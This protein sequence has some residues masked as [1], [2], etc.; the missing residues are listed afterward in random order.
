MGTGSTDVTDI[1]TNPHGQVVVSVI[2]VCLNCVDTLPATVDSLHKQTWPWREWVVMD[3]ASKDGTQNVVMNSAERPACF[4][5]QPDKGIYDAMNKALALATGDVVYFLNADDALYDEN[6]LADVAREFGADPE[7]DFL[8]G[9]IVIRKPHTRTHKRYGYINRWTL[10][11]EDLCHQAVFVRRSLFDKVGKFDLQWR[12]SADYD[13]FLRVYAAGRKVKYID[14]RVAYFAAGGFH[15]TNAKALAD[16]RQALR[17]RYVSPLKLTVGSFLSR[18]AHK[19][20]KL[21]HG[22]YKIGESLES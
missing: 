18:A 16:E 11:Y 21:L 1:A 15:A 14:R 6:V 8:F 9:S 17:L 19:V 10:P 2:T 20:S 12:T 7:L 22:G 5:S 13:W 3:G 4:V